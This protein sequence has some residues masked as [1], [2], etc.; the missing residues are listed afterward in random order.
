VIRWERKRRTMESKR[1][2]WGR[3]SCPLGE[4]GSDRGELPPFE[5]RG[6]PEGEDSLYEG[7][8]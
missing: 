2:K 7:K 6:T 8:R 3:R 1:R 5:S 4:E